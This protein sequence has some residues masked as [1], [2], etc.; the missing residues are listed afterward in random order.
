MKILFK[1]TVTA[2]LTA[3]IAL[4]AGCT[5]PST[6]TTPVS[7]TNRWLE[8]LRLVPEIKEPIADNLDITGAV[9]IQDYAYLAEKQAKYPA[10]AEVPE[11][12]QLM[13][14]NQFWNPNH[15]NADEW[16]LTVGFNR[17]DMD[18]EIFYPLAGHP[19]QYEAILGR[20]N[21]ENI[22]KALKADPL[23]SDLKTVTYAGVD[24]YSAGEDGI[25][26]SRRSNLHPLGQG[27]RVALV[28]NLVFATGFTDTMEE[29][30]DAYK[31]NTQSLADLETYQ[32]LADGLAEL[33]AFTA[34]FSTDSQS[35]S[36]VKEIFKDIIE[37]PGEDD[38]SSARRIMAEQMQ[39]EVQ[40]KPY[41]AYATGAGLD[42][43]G[44]YMAIV[45][46]NADKDTATYNAKALKDQ[47]KQSKTETGTP[48]PDIIDS[49]EVKSDDRLTLAKLYGTT[50]Y[51]W[52]GFDMASVYDSLLMYKG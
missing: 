40:L 13:Q 52:K 45:L 33:D 12:M 16:K 26:L 7:Q 38:N 22:E 29:M 28:D 20:F 49:M 21:R 17:D 24:F 41:Q 34:L 5:Q 11:Q 6:Q 14:N 15:Y 19:K 47:I 43:K 4:H 32:L 51:A 48:W 35:Q 9:Y 42:E 30:I 46:L 1:V 18:R 3:A 10:V 39:R 37:N 2:F 8:M 25:N 50:A 23:N 36:H 44:Y 27:T 31:N